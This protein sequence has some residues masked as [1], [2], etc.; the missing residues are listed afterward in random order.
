MRTVLGLCF[1]GAK[2]NTVLHSQAPALHPFARVQAPW[3]NRGQGAVIIF[4]L[5]RARG[6][7]GG[8]PWALNVGHMKTLNVLLIAGAI[9]LTT[10]TLNAKW[11]SDWS[12]TEKHHKDSVARAVSPNGTIKAIACSADG[13]TVYVACDQVWSK[14]PDMKTQTG[15]V[16]NKAQMLL[17]K[18]VDGGE[19]WMIM[20]E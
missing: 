13:K 2:T 9:A 20:G 12:A 17:F 15:E 3:T 7:A 5:V 10:L 14:G 19:T 18:S 11:F 4:K 6:V 1:H 8:R 16:A